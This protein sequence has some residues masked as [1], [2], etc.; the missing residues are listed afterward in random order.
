MKSCAGYVNNN[1][2]IH[3][4]LHE[5]RHNRGLFYRENVCLILR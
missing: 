1:L 2:I 5:N 4:E 3:F